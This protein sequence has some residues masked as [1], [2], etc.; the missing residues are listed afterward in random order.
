[1]KYNFSK[2]SGASGTSS[3]QVQVC[4]M[5]MLLQQEVAVVS[6]GVLS[7]VSNGVLSTTSNGVLSTVYNGV[8][9]IISFLNSDKLI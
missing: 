4:A 8:L 9:S 5:L 7:T 1:M 2:L 3:S 6:N